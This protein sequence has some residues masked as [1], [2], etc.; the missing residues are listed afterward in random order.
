MQ[1]LSVTLHVQFDAIKDDHRLGVGVNRANT[2]Y[3]HRSTLIKITRMHVH[4][5]VTTEFRCH[6]LVNRQAIAVR[7][8]AVGSRYRS[9]VLIHRGKS[10]TQ[11]SNVHLL[12]L[13]TR[14]NSDLL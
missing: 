7:D 6:L 13:V 14:Y 5:D 11:Q 3:E 4:T 2:T 8:E 1:R 9:T 10:I 12:F